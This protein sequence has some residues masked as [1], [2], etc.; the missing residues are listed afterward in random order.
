[1]VKCSF[2]THAYTVQRYIMVTM[3]SVLLTAYKNGWENDTERNAR[4]S[5]TTDTTQGHYRVI[6]QLAPLI[7]SRSWFW[8]L[9]LYITN[10]RERSVYVQAIELSPWLWEATA[11]SAFSTQI[12]HWRPKSQV[13]AAHW[14]CVNNNVHCTNGTKWTLTIYKQMTCGWS[15]CCAHSQLQ[16][17][18]NKLQRVA[19]FI[20]QSICNRRFMWCA[21]CM[22]ACSKLTNSRELYGLAYTVYGAWKIK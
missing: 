17:L 7:Y 21:A 20:S 3:I 4:I 2:F 10:R 5:K 8:E 1:M 19:E 11:L 16:N 13:Y 22:H 14:T 12:S 9:S 18:H 6:Q 15:W